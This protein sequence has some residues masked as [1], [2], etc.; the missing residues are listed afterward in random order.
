MCLGVPGKVIEVHETSALVDFWG[1]QREVKLEL[2]GEKLQ[3]GDYIINHLGYAVRKI[4][5]EQIYDTL[6]LYEVVL[7]EA[8]VDPIATDIF[9]EMAPGGSLKEI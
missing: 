8:G 3:P 7:T 1:V 9:C 6:A 2:V 4:E 5:D